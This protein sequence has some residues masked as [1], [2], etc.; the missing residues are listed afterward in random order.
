MNEKE[1]NLIIIGGMIIM[2]WTI[3]KKLDDVKREIWEIQDAKCIESYADKSKR[4]K[5]EER[6]ETRK[7]LI[8]KMKKLKS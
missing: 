6:D 3:I 2:G 5:R 1:K 4:R 8:S 7:W